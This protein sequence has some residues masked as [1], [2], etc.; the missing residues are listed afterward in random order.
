MLAANATAALTADCPLDLH[1][2]KLWLQFL[3]AR[4]GQQL[5][6]IKGVFHCAE[7]DHAVAV[8][9]IRDWL[10]FGPL[11]RPAPYDVA[12]TAMLFDWRADEAEAHD[13]AGQHPEVVADLTR[14]MQ[15]AARRG[16]EIAKTF[17]TSGEL[18]LSPEEIER[19]RQLGYV[20]EGDK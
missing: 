13:L 5:L 17:A 1:A 19:L 14:R 4:R 8:H 7:S 15:E 6:R 9:G 20:G 16:R 11:E 3:C 12:P 2:L 18:K 10:E